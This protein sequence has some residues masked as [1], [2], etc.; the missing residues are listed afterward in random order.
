ML[1]VALPSASPLQ[2]FSLAITGWGCRCSEVLGLLEIA[3]TTP[4]ECE[5]ASS[6][7]VANPSTKSSVIISAHMFSYVDMCNV[8][9]YIYIYMC[10]CVCA[11][12]P[13]EKD[14]HRHCLVGTADELDVH[15]CCC[16]A[17]CI[18]AHDIH[19]CVRPAYIM[20]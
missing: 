12:R 15:R 2:S 1:V 20:F 8:C 7:P 18:R 11:Y 4:S 10:V 9:V 16:E 17:V 3:Q 19:M 14:G 6:S 5:A 13:R